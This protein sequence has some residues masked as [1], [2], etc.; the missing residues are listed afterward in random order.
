MKVKHYFIIWTCFFAGC[1][2]FKQG[3]KSDFDSRVGTRIETL[4]PVIIQENSQTT[5]E[6]GLKRMIGDY[7]FQAGT[8][9]LAVLAMALATKLGLKVKKNGNGKTKGVSDEAG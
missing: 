6:T 8:S 5:T 4:V 1:S 3:L 9:T 7:G 2:I